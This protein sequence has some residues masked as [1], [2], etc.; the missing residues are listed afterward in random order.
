[1]GEEVQHI[2]PQDLLPYL[3]EVHDSN[4]R[5]LEMLSEEQLDFRPAPEVMSIRQ[6]FYHMYLKQKFYVQSII[7]REMDDSEYRNWLPFIPK[8]KE[9]LYSFIEGVFFET[10]ELFEEPYWF[11]TTIETPAGKRPALYLILGDLAHQL[12][13]R[14]QLF[15]YMRLLGL[16]PP[17]SGNFLGRETSGE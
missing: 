4:M 15:T 3:A 12:H 10:Q 9:M 17:D 8:S 6:L 7:S 2:T 11:T 16:T 14:G 1:M 13:H 5:C